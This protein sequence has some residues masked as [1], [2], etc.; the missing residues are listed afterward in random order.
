[1]RVFLLGLDWLILFEINWLSY[2][3]FSQF[4]PIGVIFSFGF[5]I[6][7]SYLWHPY[8]PP[9]SPHFVTT[10]LPPSRNTAV[11]KMYFISMG[12]VV[13]IRVKFAG[14][15]MFHCPTTF[16][17]FLNRYQIH[18]NLIDQHQSL[19]WRYFVAL[20][21]I[22][23]KFCQNHQH[24]YATHDHHG[25]VFHICSNIYSYISIDSLT[26]LITTLTLIIYCWY[27]ISWQSFTKDRLKVVHT[28]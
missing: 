12:S 25:E 15:Y 9:I 10:C 22:H 13:P 28:F 23:V 6:L 11:Y 14:L 26:L 8:N 16:W 21:N 18:S 19:C 27:Y 20:H 4:S 3:T 24:I 1:M 17:E 7:C 5:S 2:Y